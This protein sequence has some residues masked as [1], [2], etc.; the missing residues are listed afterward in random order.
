MRLFLF[1]SIFKTVPAFE[2]LLLPIISSKFVFEF[3]ETPRS[4][5]IDIN[6]DFV[7]VF[8]EEYCGE[9]VS[10]L[11]FTLTK[12][13]IFSPHTFSALSVVPVHIAE[14]AHRQYSPS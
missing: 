11:L 1:I 3:I 12:Y 8:V 9:R 13:G 7:N 14:N 6:C 5:I 2:V 10:P 4:F